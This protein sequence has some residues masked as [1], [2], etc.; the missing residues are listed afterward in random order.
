[1]SRFAASTT[2][3]DSKGKDNAQTLFGVEQIP[4]DNQIRNI[5]DGISAAGLEPIF[6]WSI[7]RS[8]LEDIW[9]HTSA[10]RTIY[11]LPS[12]ARNISRPRKST[13]CVALIELTK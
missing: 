13:V 5:L 11:C 7:K 2:A 12:M 3:S 1:V 9:Q 10:L 4:S 8:S 6:S